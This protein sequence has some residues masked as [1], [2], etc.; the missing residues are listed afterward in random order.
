MSTDIFYYKS[1][2]DFHPV[3]VEQKWDI[4]ESTEKLIKVSLVQFRNC[5]TLFLKY[6]PQFRKLTSQYYGPLYILSSDPNL[7]PDLDLATSRP[8]VKPKIFN[9]NE[10]VYR[11]YAG[12]ISPYLVNDTVIYGNDADYHCMEV[13]SS[14]CCI[15]RSTY[16][17][18]FSTY[19]EA[20][21]HA[22]KVKKILEESAAT[23]QDLVFDPFGDRKKV[24]DII[25]DVENR[26]IRTG[27]ITRIYDWVNG[28]GC[29]YWISDMGDPRFEYHFHSDSPYICFSLIDAAQMVQNVSTRKIFNVGDIVYDVG[30][31]FSISQYRVLAVKPMGRLIAY[32][33]INVD[34][35]AHS[36]VYS[37]NKDIFNTMG[38]AKHY[39]MKSEMEEKILKDYS[40]TSPMM[41]GAFSRSPSPEIGER[42]S[43]IV[44]ECNEKELTPGEFAPMLDSPKR[45][46]PSELPCKRGLKF[47]DDIGKII[48]SSGCVREP[49]PLELPA[50]AIAPKPKRARRERKALLEY[51]KSSIFKTPKDPKRVPVKTKR[52]GYH[53]YCVKCRK[54]FASDDE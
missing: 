41:G 16:E 46:P 50:P 37:D 47:A 10:T 8:W 2:S 43:S 6:F 12:V 34:T 11:Y 19:S 51:G 15:L 24:G 31:D 29:M 9:V 3:R 38:M 27:K 42:C 33:V 20:S 22:F 7:H 26:S 36:M 35:C 44:F 40:P 25:Y 53:M 21:L 45:I 13:G 23:N 17:E 54:A 49:T 39:V 32:G 28:K 5:E 52:L 4:P 30:M 18:L 1:D 48:T 14:N